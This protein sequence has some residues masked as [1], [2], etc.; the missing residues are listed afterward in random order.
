MLLS[1][2]VVGLGVVASASTP[3][4][5][6]VP[7]LSREQ[8]ESLRGKLLELDR[9]A[10][11]ARP[12]AAAPPASVLVTQGEINSY[13]NLVLGPQL[14]AGLRNVEFRLDSGRI[15]VH[16]MADLDQVKAQ[17]GVTS[18]W[19]PLALLSGTVSIELGARLKCDGGF[20]TFEVDDVRLGPM[21]VPPALLS[22]L[23][24]SA[25]R[26]QQNPAGFDILA[27]FRLPY[28][29]KRVRVQPGRA[30]LEY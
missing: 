5:A 19:N 11:R 13:V 29:L 2:F 12:V 16:A 14:P 30:S 1:A 4:P 25:T 7:P 8:A 27:P 23:V 3:P 6:P 24:A 21:A 10:K 18:I 26:T 17:M 20:G 15:E 22:Q 9:R 28:G